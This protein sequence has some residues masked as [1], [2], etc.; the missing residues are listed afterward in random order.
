M[1]T[2]GTS[3]NDLKD[4]STEVEDVRSSSGK[5]QNLRGFIKYQSL[6]LFDNCKHIIYALNF[7]FFLKVYRVKR[8]HFNPNA[9]DPMWKKYQLQAIQSYLQHSDNG[10]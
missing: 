7:P 6:H 10:G 3:Y 5:V 1:K 4:L 2:F 9:E 8:R